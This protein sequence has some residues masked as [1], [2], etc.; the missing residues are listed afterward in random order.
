ME[1]LVLFGTWKFSHICNLFLVGLN[2][3]LYFK[4]LA[5]CDKFIVFNIRKKLGGELETLTDNTRFLYL[6]TLAFYNISA[7]T[8]W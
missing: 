5:I 6:L 7:Y 2:K 1:C 3:S 4:Y 8:A